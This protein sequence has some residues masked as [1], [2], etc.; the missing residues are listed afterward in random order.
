MNDARQGPGAALERVMGIEPTY[1]AWEA[2]VLPLNYTRSGRD[3]TCFAGRPRGPACVTR[4]ARR[5]NAQASE[6]RAVAQND[7]SSVAPGPV[8]A[9][10][11]QRA[12][13]SSTNSSGTGREKPIV[14][15]PN[16]RSRIGWFIS[17]LIW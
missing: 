9:V 1:E 16:S 8:C 5:A 7:R 12:A 3:S 14:Q 2:A 13:A 11:F 15:S 6:M 17:S 10:P 4:A